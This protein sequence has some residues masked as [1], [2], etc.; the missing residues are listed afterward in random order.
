MSPLLEA[1]LTNLQGDERA[2]AETVS[3]ADEG[4]DGLGGY[5]FNR[6][7]DALAAFLVEG[8]ARSQEESKQVIAAFDP[9][10]NVDRGAIAGLQDLHEGDEE[11]GDPVQIHCRQDYFNALFGCQT[12]CGHENEACISHM[13]CHCE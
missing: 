2:I 6:Q 11:V 10:L 13:H 7:R 1:I 8:L 9:G 4:A 3:G 5:S 12:S